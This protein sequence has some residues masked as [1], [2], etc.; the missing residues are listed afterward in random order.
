RPTQDSSDNPDPVTGA[1]TSASSLPAR[2][3]VSPPS[4]LR[5]ASREISPGLISAPTSRLENPFQSLPESPRVNP[6]SLGH[7]HPS[8]KAPENDTFLA[9]PT[10]TTSALIL[11]VSPDNISLVLVEPSKA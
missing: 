3:K 4:R 2:R 10:S 9:E 5:W 7:S 11:R 1:S 6:N 8:G